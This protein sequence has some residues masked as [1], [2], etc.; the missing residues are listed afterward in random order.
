[1][2]LLRVFTSDCLTQNEI[3]VAK[4]ILISLTE[5]G[6]R[7]NKQGVQTEKVDMSR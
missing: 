1:M 6:Y 3:R 7:Q 5:T 2:T 4:M